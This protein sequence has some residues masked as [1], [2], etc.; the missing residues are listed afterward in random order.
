MEKSKHGSCIFVYPYEDEIGSN[1][2]GEIMEFV[3][4]VQNSWIKHEDDGM[5]LNKIDKVLTNCM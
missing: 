3:R 1:V 4:D 2:P 5:D